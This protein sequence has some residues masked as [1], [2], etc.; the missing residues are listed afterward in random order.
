MPSS[1]TAGAGIPADDPGVPATPVP[2]ATPEPL[3]STGEVRESDDGTQP[4]SPTLVSSPSV[5][6]P[7][8]ED[9]LEAIM[10]ADYVAPA[11]PADEAC[12][13]CLAADEVGTPTVAAEPL[14][15]AVPLAPVAKAAPGGLTHAARRALA[16]A[17]A[18]RRAM[19]ASAMASVATIAAGLAAEI[20]L[21]AELQAEAAEAAAVQAAFGSD[22]SDSGQFMRRGSC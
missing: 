13:T 15:P 21:D 1:S 18:E 8:V 6:E 12:T 10:S 11:A 14:A 3:S 4:P 9:E 7:A 19:Q 17:A 20:A 2:E 16:A 5:A 22:E